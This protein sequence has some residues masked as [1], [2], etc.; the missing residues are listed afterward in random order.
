MGVPAANPVTHPATLFTNRT[1]VTVTAAPGSYVGLT[2]GG[3]IAG[4]GTV[5]EA[6]SLTMPLSTLLTP[7]AARLVVTMQNREPYV[8]DLNVIVPAVVTFNPTSIEANVTTPVTVGVYEADGVTPRPNV[9]VWAEGLDLTTPYVV[10]GAGRPVRPHHHLSVRA[11]DRHRGPESRRSLGALPDRA[12][13]Q[14]APARRSRSLR[15]DRDRARRH[16]RAE[17]SGRPPRHGERTGAH[18]VGLRERRPRRQHE[19][20]Q[21]QPHAARGRERA[22]R[23][24]GV[25]VRPPRGGVPD[26]RGLRDGYRDT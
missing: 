7:G 17:P 26:H 25:R 16:V 23:D 15:D 8:A 21:P 10:T 5:D 6:G 20:D 19:R 4:A 22:R 13:G 1:A 24:R 2:Q 11:G 18:A 12:P 14:R 3:A 9:R